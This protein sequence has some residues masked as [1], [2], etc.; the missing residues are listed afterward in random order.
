MHR[1][2]FGRC[3]AAT[4][5]RGSP[6]AARFKSAIG[7]AIV[8]PVPATLLELAHCLGLQGPSVHLE[9]ALTHPSY[10][11]EHKGETQDNQR[12]E[13]LGDAVLGLV[14]SEFLMEQF[15]DAREGEL[16]LMRSALV[17][18]DALAA[19]AR[20]VQLGEVLRLGRGADAAGERSQK[21]VL[22]DAVEAIAGAVYIDLGVEPARQVARVIVGEQ[23]KKLASG[24][25][26][27]R[28]PKSEL[29]ERV[30]ARGSASPKYRVVE[31]IG[32]DH[33]RE[34]V[35]AVDVDGQVA[36]EGR[37]RSKKQAEQEAARN[38]MERS[39]KYSL[40]QMRR[41]LPPPRYTVEDL[42]EEKAKAGEEAT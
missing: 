12:L 16:S 20:D 35:V 23:I 34:F 7:C 15:P 39:I 5:D 10:A 42:P 6:R 31:T 19:W 17:N 22:A 41:D 40:S 36:G 25:G 1:S 2:I 8:A 27:G 4:G 14:V 38:A 37:G 28:D 9:Q 11:N 21:N 29:Q 30:Q 18:A 32:P 3:V 33:N 24:P 13:F 26:V